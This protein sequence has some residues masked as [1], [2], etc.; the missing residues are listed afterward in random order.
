MVDFFVLLFV[1]VCFD[2]CVLVLQGFVY[3]ERK[4]EKSHEVVWVE[5]WGLSRRREGERI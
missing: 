2:L 3:F 4:N 5:R 1:F